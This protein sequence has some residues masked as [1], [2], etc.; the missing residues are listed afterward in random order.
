MVMLG[1]CLL[2]QTLDLSPVTDVGRDERD[3]MSS[4]TQ[5]CD[6]PFGLFVIK[7]SDHNSRSL[8]TEPLYN[9]FADTRSAASDY[10]SFPL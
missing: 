10:G 5:L 3:S 7:V 6:H 4:S 1:E 8:C 2:N 9:C